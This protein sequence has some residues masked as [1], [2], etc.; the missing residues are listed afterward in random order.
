MKSLRITSGGL[1]V[2]VGMGLVTACDVPTGM[3]KLEQQWILPV[4]E[5]SIEVGEF[6]P[7]RVGMTED[8]TAFTVDVEPIVFNETLGALCPV[9]QPLDGLTVPKPEF[10]GV[11]HESVSPPEDVESAQVQEGRIVV[12]AENGFD[13]DPLRPPGG[14]SGTVRLA[15]RDGSPTGPVLDEVLVDG[16]VEGF[17]PGATLS[18][19]LEYSGPVA[20]DIFVTADVDSPAGGL[21]PGNWVQIRTSNRIEI[22]A[23]PEVLEAASAEIRVAGEVFDL[24][25]TDLDVADISDDM[26]DQ[27]QSGALQLELV[28]P[29]A[30]G[31]VLN[32]TINGPTMDAPVVLIAPIPAAPTSSVR[33]EVSQAELRAFLGAPGVIMTGQGTVD[34]G[35]G[36]VTLAPGQIMTIETK[37]DLVILVG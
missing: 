29:W 13:F 12:E 36:T 11:F 5:T 21:E 10:T 6:L 35:A 33:V 16:A 20:S 3:P 34:L 17:A 14:E 15:L 9:C 4:T 30:V 19:E 1:T 18:R 22:T 25:A 37:I 26:V 7:D 23:T 32:L 24:G 28:N 31:A 2:L 27:I 8:S